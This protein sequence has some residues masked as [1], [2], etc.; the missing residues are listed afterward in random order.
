MA[1]RRHPM[2]PALFGLGVLVGAAWHRR[3]WRERGRASERALDRPQ[4]QRRAP[5]VE[6]PQGAS[7]RPEPARPG[8]ERA[9]VLGYQ[10][11]APTP[12]V[13]P[14]AP[15]VGTHPGFTIGGDGSVIRKPGI[16]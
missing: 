12:P 1:R 3:P 4:G 15:D 10:R 6:H 5:A 13:P 2:A 9:S 8:G 7:W 16:H 14:A 11:A